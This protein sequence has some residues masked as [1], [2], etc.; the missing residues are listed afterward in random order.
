MSHESVSVTPPKPTWI[1]AF[2][3]SPCAFRPSKTPGE[4]EGVAEARIVLLKPSVS[5]SVHSIEHL[6]VLESY[7]SA[8]SSVVCA[9]A[10]SGAPFPICGPSC[11]PTRP[12]GHAQWSNCMSIVGS[13]TVC[14]ASAFSPAMVRPSHGI[15]RYEEVEWPHILP[16]CEDLPLDD[17]QVPWR[18]PRLPRATAA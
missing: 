10:S 3:V 6:Y 18:S 5:V 14:A 11:P 7:V 4:K 13:V 17:Q 8:S 15:V 2:A 9:F 12:F 1:G 16:V